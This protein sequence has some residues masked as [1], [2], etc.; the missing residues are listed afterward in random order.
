MLSSYEVAGTT[1]TARSAHQVR[2]DGPDAML[3]TLVASDSLLFIYSRIAL[4]S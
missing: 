4:R 1:T 2:Q 3:R